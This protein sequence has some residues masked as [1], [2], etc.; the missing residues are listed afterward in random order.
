[1]R[2]PIFF[3]HI[4]KTGGTS[5]RLALAAHFKPNETMPTL[6]MMTERGGLY[7]HIT[8]IGRAMRNEHTSAKLL[9][10]HYHF[11]AHN[12]MDRPIKLVVLRDPL[13]Q[14]ISHMRHFIHA[15]DFTAQEC[16]AALDEGRS[17]VQDNPMTRYLGG[18]LL[19]LNEDSIRRKHHLL[20]VGPIAGGQ[21]DSA[22]ENLASCDAVGFTERLPEF[23]RQARRIT[24]LR[25]KN[26]K[27]NEGAGA[28]LQL[29]KAQT[30]KLLEIN[31]H[32][33]E[34]YQKA[35][36]LFWPRRHFWRFLQ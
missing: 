1:M 13:K 30:A 19:P 33:V 9:F 15:G 7:P 4:P 17:L 3:C 20:M 10:G 6:A 35:A 11:S 22:M 12:F 18:S 24:G 34:L 16:L 31:R 5:V 29:T 28:E 36:D 8:D 25:L 26:F 23:F 14:L 27:I 2:R 21:V 32:D